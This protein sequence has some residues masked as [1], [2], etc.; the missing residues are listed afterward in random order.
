MTLVSSLPVWCF[1]A[2]AYPFFGFGGVGC[3]FLM[4]G[5]DDRQVEISNLED[6]SNLTISVCPGLEQAG[7]RLEPGIENFLQL[8]Q[9]YESISMSRSKVPCMDDSFSSLT[10][11][12]IVVELMSP[13]HQNNPFSVDSRMQVLRVKKRSV[14][15]M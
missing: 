10:H 12:P 14:F 1:I 6:G 11:I 13:R 5:P 4:C 7:R 2:S 3:L 15:I 9:P 8:W